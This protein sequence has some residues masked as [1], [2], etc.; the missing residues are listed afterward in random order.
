MGAKYV[1]VTDTRL[2]KT[3]LGFLCSNC[4]EL[5]VMGKFLP[6]HEMKALV[7]WR[8]SSMYS[9]LLPLLDARFNPVARPPCHTL[10]MRVGPWMFRRRYKVSCP[11]PL[12]LG[13]LALS[14]VNTPTK[15]SLLQWVN[16]P[17]SKLTIHFISC[18]V[19]E[20]V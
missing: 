3:T 13:H 19:L 14:L 4:G 6:V 17:G 5:Q 18:R 12:F 7:E 10:S 11:H 1:F 15:Q 2:R 9:S 20:Y 8:F 16:R